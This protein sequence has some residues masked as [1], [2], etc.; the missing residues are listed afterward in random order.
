[1]EDRFL[2]MDEAVE[3]LG[4]SEHTLRAAAK[5]GHIVWSWD[6]SDRRV[7]RYSEAGISAYL[8]EHVVQNEILFEE[9]LY[10][11][12]GKTTAYLD[13]D[14][15][16]VAFLRKKG[17]LEGIM[18]N[19]IWYYSLSSVQA[20]KKV[21]DERDALRHEIEVDGEKYLPTHAAIKYLSI[22]HSTLFR[23]RDNGE[24]KTITRHVG[25]NILWFFSKESLDE[26]RIVTE[27]RFIKGI[28]YISFSSA[29]LYLKVPRKF[30]L[31]L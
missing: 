19:G 5:K 23:W 22:S 13:L 26:Q 15:A 21:K 25:H 27:R 31:E 30:I 9:E 12:I 28:E 2:S 18:H 3:K 24:I 6:R 16:L 29:H 10:Y 8:S 11:S 17:I 1:M 20:Y 4:I 14:T 7:K